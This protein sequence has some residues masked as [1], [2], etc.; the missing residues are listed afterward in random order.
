MQRF[1]NLRNTRSRN[2]AP[3][4]TA[5]TPLVAYPYDPGAAKK[6]YARQLSPTSKTNPKGTPMSEQAQV[7]DTVRLTITVEG[8]VSDSWGDLIA[9]GRFINRANIL[10]EILSRATVLVKTTHPKGTPMSEQAQ[11]GDTVR[12]TI[13]VEGVV[14]ASLRGDLMVDG[15]FLNTANT[16]VEIL[17]RATVPAVITN[18]KGTPTPE[19]AQVG[20]TVRLTITLEGEVYKGDSG[21]LF[22]GGW[23]VNAPD[24]TV[25]ILSRATPP[26]PSEPNTLHSDKNGDVW[27]VHSSGELRCLSYPGRGDDAIFYAP[28]R[29]LVLQ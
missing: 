1:H 23:Y 2:S 25:E 19:Q 8:V 10:V 14:L 13:T 5:H 16:L 17:S 20:D 28:F 6:R 26:L 18:P 12:L 11:V 29:Q 4:D 27:K 3:S 7:G 24:R 21:R 22:V 15:C 9:G